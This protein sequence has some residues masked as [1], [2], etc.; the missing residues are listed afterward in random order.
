M[1]V[2][3]TILALLPLHHPALILIPQEIKV[4]Q[5]STMARLPFHYQVFQQTAQ[6]ITVV[7][8][9][10]SLAAVYFP[11]RIP[12]SQAIFQMMVVQFAVMAHLPF[13]IPR[14]LRMLQPTTVVGFS[15]LAQ[16]KLLIQLF[17]EIQPTALV[18]LF[19]PAVSS[20]FLVP[21]FL[22]TLLEPA[23]PFR[24]LII[25]PPLIP[26]LKLPTPSS[27]TALMVVIMLV[28]AQLDCLVLRLQQIT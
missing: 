23:E 10:S 25:L 19:A 26:P 12:P 9:A 8:Y 27:L 11:S 16:L 2:Q 6:E 1:L 14:W 7:Q 15:T 13:R 21:L 20:N 17:M 5:S 22:L 24:I 28:M 3:F 4:E 18:V